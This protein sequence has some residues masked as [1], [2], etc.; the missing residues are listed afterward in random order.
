MKIKGEQE[1]WGQNKVPMAAHPWQSSPSAHCREV[2]AAIAVSA[3]LFQTI[4]LFPGSFGVVL[5]ELLCAS[6]A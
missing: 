2:C 3:P 1:S 5:W 4:V 6:A